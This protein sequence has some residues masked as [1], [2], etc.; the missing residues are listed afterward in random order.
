VQA[1]LPKNRT[2]PTTPWVNPARARIVGVNAFHEKVGRSQGD[3]FWYLSVTLFFP[4]RVATVATLIS[5]ALSADLHGTK[6]NVPSRCLLSSTRQSSR[7]SGRRFRTRCGAKTRRSAACRSRQR[8]WKLPY[9]RRW[10][11]RDTAQGR[12]FCVRA[13]STGSI[14]WYHAPINASRGA[15]EE[16]RTFRSDTAE[17]RNGPAMRGR[18]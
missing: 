1:P 5:A 16:L 4:S 15:Q 6:P 7:R 10:T 13:G 18:I 9:E 3:S 2:T 12:G 14:S 17:Q 11:V 8:K